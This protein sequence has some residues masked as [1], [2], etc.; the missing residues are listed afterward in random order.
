M[1][2]KFVLCAQ[3]QLLED[4]LS[5]AVLPEGITIRAVDFGAD[6]KKISRLALDRDLDTMSPAYG[7]SPADVPGEIC[8]VAERDGDLIGQISCTVEALGSVQTNIDLWVTGVFV[9]GPERGHGV[10]RALGAAAVALC[11]RWRRQTAAGLGRG[12]M[13]AISVSADTLPGSKGEAVIE[14]MTHRCEDLEE[15]AAEEADLRAVPK[16]D[17]F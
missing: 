11:E 4:V 17:G 1:P 13:G 5:E 3:N 15:Q 16:P 10:S 12:P 9:T 14:R 8:L 6:L 2:A 7:M